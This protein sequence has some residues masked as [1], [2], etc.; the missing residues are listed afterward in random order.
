MSFP[1]ELS[2]DLY[3]SLARCT[4]PRFI[5]T[6]RKISVMKIGNLNLLLQAN[7]LFTTKVSGRA[8]AANENFL[9]RERKFSFP[10]CRRKSYW[11]KVIEKRVWVELK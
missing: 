1:L 10:N 6:V 3:E 5:E 11:G 4:N 2:R 7:I 8:N 9:H